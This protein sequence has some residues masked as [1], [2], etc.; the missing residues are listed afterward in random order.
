MAGEQGA[1]CSALKSPWGI[2]WR[3]FDRVAT[4]RPAFLGILQGRTAQG[5]HK[6]QCRA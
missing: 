5:L 4:Y 2:L 1:L 3:S 6:W